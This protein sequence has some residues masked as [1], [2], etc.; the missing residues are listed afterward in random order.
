MGSF[1]NIRLG[2]Q[3]SHLVF[4]LFQVTFITCF[5]KYQLSR[6]VNAPGNPIE[7]PSLAK[8]VDRTA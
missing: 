3:G 1:E 2:N 8:P 5:S 4:I 6:A 7:I